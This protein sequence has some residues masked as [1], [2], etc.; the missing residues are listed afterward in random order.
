MPKAKNKK[1][2]KD[3]TIYQQS[4]TIADMRMER[5]YYYTALKESQNSLV[6]QQKVLEQT[7][8]DLYDA[9]RAYDGLNTMANAAEKMGVDMDNLHKKLPENIPTNETH[10]FKQTSFLTESGKVN[11]SFKLTPKK[12][13]GAK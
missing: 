13:G 5:Q 9:I 6:E 8:K 7:N 3:V 11:H 2:N 12:K 4:L 1:V 10:D